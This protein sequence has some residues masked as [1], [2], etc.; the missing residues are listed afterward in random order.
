MSFC[1]LSDFTVCAALD[2]LIQ[3][4]C[5][6][7]LYRNFSLLSFKTSVKVCLFVCLGFL[8]LV[9]GLDQ[10]RFFFL[11]VVCVLHLY[12]V[13]NY[14]HNFIN[15]ASCAGSVYVGTIGYL[16]LTIINVCPLVSI[17]PETIL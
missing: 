17:L 12:S 4:N 9:T 10:L 11:S 16:F 6:S 1:T 3:L 15:Y 2:I 8:G 5:W 14:M 13:T 7:S